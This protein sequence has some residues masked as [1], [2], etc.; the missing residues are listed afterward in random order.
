[1][2]GQE[3]PTA[4]DGD[5]ISELAAI[6]DV[7]PAP[8]PADTQAAELTPG[9]RPSGDTDRAGSGPGREERFLGPTHQQAFW[10][11]FGGQVLAQSAVAAMHTVPRE[12]AIHSVHGYF[13]R[14]GDAKKPLEI[15]VD[16][17]RDG[18]SFSARRAQAYQGGVPILSMI[19]SF[20][21]ASPGPSHQMEV[22]PGIPQPEDLAAPHELIGHVKHPIM[23][24]WAWGRPFEIRH[25]DRPLYVSPDPHPLAHNA[26]WMRARTKLGDDPQIHRAAILYASDYTIMESTLRR[27]GLYWSKPEMRV[28]SLD[29]ALWWHRDA[30]ADEWLLYVQASPAA[31]G[32]RGLGQG[33]IFTREGEL[34]ASVAQEG[35]VRRP[36]GIKPLIKE[37]IRRTAVGSSRTSRQAHRTYDD[38]WRSRYFG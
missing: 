2:P 19:A 24:E 38:S 12:R 4:A 7:Q 28:A 13:L 18:R 35:M 32:S 36:E 11:V 23:Q 21:T 6:L 26:V 29:H 1:M 17:L 3:N 25:I 22:P 37:Q 20:Q 14:P 34:V 9:Q 8:S 16:R 10:R 5:A 33:H 27:H 31:Q 30:R 15:G